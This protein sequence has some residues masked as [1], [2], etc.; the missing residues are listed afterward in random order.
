MYSTGKATERNRTFDSLYLATYGAT[1]KKN[2]RHSTVCNCL[3]VAGSLWLPTLSLSLSLYCHLPVLASV[4][5]TCAER[6]DL[7]L[8]LLLLLR[9][10]MMRRLKNSKRTGWGLQKQG[11]RVCAIS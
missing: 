8:L 1:L 9:G 7:S 3:C 11:F 4:L 10:D 5:V 6:G 2:L